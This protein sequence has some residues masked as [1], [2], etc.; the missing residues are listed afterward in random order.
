[1]KT[2]SIFWSKGFAIADKFDKEHFGE[3]VRLEEGDTR[4]E[5]QAIAEINVYKALHEKYPHLKSVY[6]VPINPNVRASIYGDSE[7]MF[8]QSP[9]PKTHF[10]VSKQTGRTIETHPVEP[11]VIQVEK[12]TDFNYQEEM[13]KCDD[14]DTLKKEWK[15][16]S[17]FNPKVKKAYIKRLKELN[18]E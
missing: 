17:G 18:K 8:F 1:M 10:A 11:P 6:P 14:A 13:N 12:S 5:A 15:F 16:L 4:E 7:A 3:T 9:A 2:E